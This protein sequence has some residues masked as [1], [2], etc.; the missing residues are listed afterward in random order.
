MDQ[1]M[2]KLWDKQ[3]SATT[4]LMMAMKTV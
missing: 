1:M 4:M 2:A 3:L